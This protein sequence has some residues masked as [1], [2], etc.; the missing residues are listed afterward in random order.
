MK[1]YN[2]G[3]RPIKIMCMLWMVLVI[4]Y[5]CLDYQPMY[6]QANIVQG[7]NIKKQETKI[8][9]RLYKKLKAGGQK[10][11]QEDVIIKLVKQDSKNM[12]VQRENV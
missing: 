4:T 7:K 5:G 2:K 1:L 8:P 6:V 11:H 9:K 3:K 10:V 12:I